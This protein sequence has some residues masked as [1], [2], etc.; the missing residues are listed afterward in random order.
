MYTVYVFQ[1][2]NGTLKMCTKLPNWGPEYNLKIDDSGFVTIQYFMAGEKFYNRITEE[3]TT[4][5]FTNVYFKE[6]IKDNNK[7][8]DIIL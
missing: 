6:F 1:E 3:E 8:E 5:R 4:V 7:S 2:D